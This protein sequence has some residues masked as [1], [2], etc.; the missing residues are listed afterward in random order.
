VP[1]T[2]VPTAHRRVGI[3]KVFYFFDRSPA[4]LYGCCFYHNPARDGINHKLGGPNRQTGE[5]LLSPWYPARG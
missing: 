1:V 5:Q 4:L 2:D 3:R